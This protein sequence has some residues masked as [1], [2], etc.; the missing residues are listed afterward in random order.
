[1]FIQILRDIDGSWLVELCLVT[2]IWTLLCHSRRNAQCRRLIIGHLV[3]LNKKCNNNSCVSPTIHLFIVIAG[4]SIWNSS[5]SAI[6]ALCSYSKFQSLTWSLYNNWPWIHMWIFKC[7]ALC[8]SFCGY[9]H[10]KAWSW[11]LWCTISW[12]LT[13]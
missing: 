6:V 2:W 3:A 4:T 7:S 8:N 1:M 9:C 13:Y 12:Y 5:C 10:F 11:N